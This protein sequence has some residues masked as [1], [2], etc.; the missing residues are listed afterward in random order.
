MGTASDPIAC[1]GIQIAPQHILV[2][3]SCL[4]QSDT[5]TRART[6]DVLDA[7]STFS[8]SLSITID[9]A[10]ATTLGIGAEA[11]PV[12]YQ[13]PLSDQD[14]LHVFTLESSLPSKDFEP[15]ILPLQTS[16]PV[17]LSVDTNVTLVHVNAQT[18]QVSVIH[19]IIYVDD[20]RC[21][22][23]VC[24]LPLD[25]EARK[26]FTNST[27]WSFL[28]QF[29][30]IRD[31]YRLLGVGGDEVTNADGI[32]GFS[33]LPQL[34]TSSLL[35]NNGVHGVHTITIVHKEVMGRPAVVEDEVSFVAG[36]LETE[37]SQIGCAGAVV[38]SRYVLTT[39][40]CTK[41]GDFKWVVVGRQNMFDR[42]ANKSVNPSGERVKIKKKIRHPRHVDGTNWYDFMLVEVETTMSQ[43]PI[44]FVDKNS[45][46]SNGTVLAYG[47]SV[48]NTGEHYQSYDL[49]MAEN[50][51]LT[52]PQCMGRVKTQMDETMMCM[53]GSSLGAVCKDDNGG[54]VVVTTEDKTKLL[55]ALVSV[56]GD[57]GRTSFYGIVSVVFSVADWIHAY[58]NQKQ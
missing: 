17:P 52:F 40:S 47:E 4:D 19:R 3:P 26:Q 20:S 6:L 41:R 30:A 53:N 21:Q 2:Q 48:Y 57:C 24:A 45:T 56:G 39:A 10:N 50:Q 7:N 28:L 38:S 49:R 23:S 33:W 18:L 8:L 5:L 11:T 46:F 37:K 51:L 12:Q 14:L 22:H 36:L 35:K 13:V 15:V 44:G 27:G 58:L 31:K 16:Y 32:W 54:P 9:V 29:D 25:I 43:T 42:S 55:Y 34:L 1:I